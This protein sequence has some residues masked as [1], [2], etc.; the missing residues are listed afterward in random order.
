MRRILSAWSPNWPIT[1][2][3]RRNPGS[4]VRAEPFGLVQSVK[5]ARRLAAV[6]APDGLFLDVTGAEALWGGEAALLDDFVA[7]MA[8]A[9]VRVR[10]AIAD[11]A[12]AA[13]AIARYGDG[14]CVLPAG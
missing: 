14:R 8:R 3:R 13:W 9:D 5:G 1:S 2:W 11:T 7:R 4:G 6:D 10:A 12:G